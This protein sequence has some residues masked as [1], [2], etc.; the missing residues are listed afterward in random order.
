VVGSR[1]LR[2]L[3]P[4]WLYG[5]IALVVGWETL[6]NGSGAWYR[7]AFW[8]LPLRDPHDGVDGSAM[9]DTLWYVRAYLWFVLLSP[10]LIWLFRR[11]RFGLVVLPLALLP[12]VEMLGQGTWVGRGLLNNLMTYGACWIL[13]FAEYDGLLAKL[14]A[15]FCV[16]AGVI[17][18]AGGLVLQFRSPTTPSMPNDL[19]YALWAAAVVLLLLRWR[20]DTSWVHRVGWFDRLVTVV[21]ARAVSIYLWHDPAIVAVGALF[22]LIGLHTWGLVKLPFVLV[23]T[24]VIVIALGWVEDLGARRRPRLLPAAHYRARHAAVSS[25]PVAP[26]QA[27]ELGVLRQE[28]APAGAGTPQQADAG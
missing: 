23:A 1:A 28:P 12:V 25:E 20:P 18:G 13:G 4:F 3:P 11:L 24:G 16:A 19:G 10:L 27:R 15:W 5:A 6:G 8:V 26:A 2:L 21:N 17:V 22:G 7:L 14:P 9:L